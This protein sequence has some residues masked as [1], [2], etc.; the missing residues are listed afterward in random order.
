MQ[1][2]HSTEALPHRCEGMDERMEHSFG[3]VA[4]DI[5]K[6]RDQEQTCECKAEQCGMRHVKLYSDDNTMTLRRIRWERTASP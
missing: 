1:L 6:P 3:A 2:R 5:S 4:E